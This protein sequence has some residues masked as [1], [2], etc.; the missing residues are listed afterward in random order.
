MQVV[1]IKI[2]I[3]LLYSLLTESFIKSVVI[4]SMEYVLN[5]VDSDPSK[6]NALEKILEDVK[7]AWNVE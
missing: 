4:H 3:S 2:A 7:K 5:K 1:L 6:Q